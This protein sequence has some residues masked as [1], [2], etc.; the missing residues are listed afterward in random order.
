M[1]LLDIIKTPITYTLW[2]I[3]FLFFTLM[4]I[5][6]TLLPKPY[7]YKNR[8]YFL[9]TTIWNKLLIAESFLFIRKTGTENL[10]TYP[11]L[12][13]III[14]NHTSAID[15][16]IME[17]LIETYP[18]IWITRIEYMKIPL[19]SILLKRM[20]IPINRYDTRKAGHALLRTYKLAKNLTSHILLFPEGTRTLDGK[21]GKFTTGFALLA[22]KLNR[23]VIPIAVSGLH[24]I[25]PKHKFFINYHAAQPT[26]TVGKPM[27]IQ[28]NESIDA[29][30]QRIH[31]WFEEELAKIASHR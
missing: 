29:F 13:S 23:P 14:M 8:L 22:K 5:P 26:L 17:D 2:V 3:T 20:N 28:P 31:T 19:F 16:M 21:L 15:I 7:R 18:H 27:T 6:L 11:N 30:T 4:C 12:P 9:L 25:F 10:P 24:K 1:S